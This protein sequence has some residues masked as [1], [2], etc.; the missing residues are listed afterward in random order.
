MLNARLKLNKEQWKE[1]ES[2]QHLKF[3]LL[4]IKILPSK[5]LLQRLSVLLA[6][7]QAGNTSENL[8]KEIKQTVYLLHW[9]K[10]DLKICVQ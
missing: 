2:K 4:G 9:A 10:A 7:L 5:K 8:L 1:K 6:Q 3:E